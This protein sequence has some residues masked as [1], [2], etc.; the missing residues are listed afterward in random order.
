MIRFWWRGYELTS[1]LDL[2]A[3]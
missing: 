2:R 1:T 3:I